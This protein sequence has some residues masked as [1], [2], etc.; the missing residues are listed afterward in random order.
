[1]ERE[2]GPIIWSKM[3]ANE[4]HLAH[5]EISRLEFFCRAALTRQVRNVFS[6][7]HD[8]R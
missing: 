2:I 7:R 1:M 3:V 6:K 5:E 4:K 8:L